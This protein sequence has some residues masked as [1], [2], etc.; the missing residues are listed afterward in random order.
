[1][2]EGRKQTNYRKLYPN[3]KEEIYDVLERSDRK[4]KYSK[5]DLKTERCSI[6]YEKGTVTYIPS[7]EDSFERLL[8]GNRQFAAESESVEDTAVKTVMIEKMLDCIKQLTSKEQELIT[9][10]FFMDKSERQLSLETGIPYMTIHD[11]K[12]KILGKL[13][14][15]M[16]K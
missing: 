9:E 6:D 4:I 1:M 11:R 10:L 2:E 14:K 13:K 16:K 3:V 7:R 15:L 8:E 12:V 5:Y